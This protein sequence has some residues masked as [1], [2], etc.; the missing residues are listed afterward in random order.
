MGLSP[1]SGSFV[2]NPFINL[3]VA[4]TKSGLEPKKKWR[5]FNKYAII[6]NGMK[7]NYDL[8]NSS[9]FLGSEF[10][11]KTEAVRRFSQFRFIKKKKCLRLHFKNKKEE[12]FFPFPST[13]RCRYELM[14]WTGS[15]EEFYVAWIVHVY[16]LPLM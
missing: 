2:I 7:F 12:S 15:K 4:L 11:I 10:K 1:V 5:R 6:P 3:N 9:F 13:S 14:L 8:C 16:V